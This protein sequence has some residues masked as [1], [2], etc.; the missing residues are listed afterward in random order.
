[1]AIQH[2]PSKCPFCGD[3]KEVASGG[4]GWLLGPIE[5]HLLAKVA[6]LENRLQQMEWRNMTINLGSGTNVHFDDPDDVIGKIAQ[7]FTECQQ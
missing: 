1:M 6:E 7:R 3:L 5:L 4:S 2:D